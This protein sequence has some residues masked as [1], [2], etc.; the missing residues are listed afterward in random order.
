M[1]IYTIPNY[2][3]MASDQILRLRAPLLAPQINF[4]GVHRKD[5]AEDNYYLDF[6]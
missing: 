2:A 5:L 4:C 1:G 6:A 3:K